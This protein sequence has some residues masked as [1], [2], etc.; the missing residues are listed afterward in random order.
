MTK[1]IFEQSQQ[2]RTVER[3]V[4][5]YYQKYPIYSVWKLKTKQIPKTIKLTNIV[6]ECLCNHE[7]ELIRDFAFEIVAALNNSDMIPSWFEKRC[8]DD[9]YT[10]ELSLIDN[11]VSILGKENSRAIKTYENQILICNDSISALNAKKTE[12]QHTLAKLSQRLSKIQNHK[13][14][15]FLSICTLFIFNYLN[16]KARIRKLQNRQVKFNNLLTAAQQNIEICKTNI[17]NAKN[18]IKLQTDNY[19]QA[20]TAKRSA[21]ERLAKNHDLL[22]RDIEPLDDYYNE[23]KEFISIK[24]LKGLEYEKIIGC[25]VIHN[26]ENNKYYVGQSKDVIKRINQHF[27]GTTPNNVIFAEDYYSSKLHDK[28]NLFSVK[29]IRLETKDELD[30]TERQLI[31]DYDARK[32]GYNGT[33]GNI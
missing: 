23:D 22:I 24:S 13:K 28:D 14:S 5:Q 27:K 26:T 21:M 1:I 30:E 33:S 4:T 6:L 7:E 15:V 31:F 20:L 3:Y 25:Y 10:N 17:V 16:S 8:I 29:I 2:Y 12:T 18:G 19:N 9:D 32:N 11:E